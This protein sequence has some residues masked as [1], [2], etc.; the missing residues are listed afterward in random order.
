MNT[1]LATLPESGLSTNFKWIER[2]GNRISPADMATRHLVFSLRMIYNHT[3]PEEYHIPGGV[4]YS[5]VGSWPLARLRDSVRNLMAEV[6]KRDD[7]TPE[8]HRILNGM[9]RGYEALIAGRLN[10]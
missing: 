8:F 6:L 2:D 10:G 5:N 7:L 9:K 3:M 1:Q 4:R